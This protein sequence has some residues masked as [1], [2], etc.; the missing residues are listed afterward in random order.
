[1]S[2]KPVSLTGLLAVLS[3]LV[4]AVVDGD[5][6]KLVRIPKAYKVADNRKSVSA[7]FGASGV[8]HDTETAKAVCV[9]V[10]GDK[11]AKW[12]KAKRLSWIAGFFDWYTFA[13]DVT[14]RGIEVFDHSGDDPIP[15]YIVVAHPDY[16]PRSDTPKAEVVAITAGDLA[17]FT[18]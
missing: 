7:L 6:R 4:L 15:V 18:G 14:V 12:S 11:A 9:S 16:V 8:F 1:M 10:H 17:T 3:G 2:P 13:D 5:K